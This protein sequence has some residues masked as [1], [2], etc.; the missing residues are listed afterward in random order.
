M[1]SIFSDDFYNFLLQNNLPKFRALQVF[2]W[3]CKHGKVS[4]A[5]MPNIGQKLQRFLQENFF[6]Y[7]PDVSDIQ[8]SIDG[9]TK[10]LL[11]LADANTIETVLIPEKDHNTLCISSQVGCAVGCKFCNTGF[12][13]FIRNLTV[14]EIIGQYIAMHHITGKEISNIV[15]M[16]MGEPLFNVENVLKSIEIFINPDMFGLS[17]RKITLSTSGI[18]PVLEKIVATLPVKL[19]ISL[20]AP[21]DEIRDKI[22]PINKKYNLKNLLHVCELYNKYN[23]FLR[24]TFEYLL[25]KDVNDSDNCAIELAKI[26]G[27]INAKVNIIRFNSWPGSCFTE[28]SAKTVIKFAKILSK[29]GIDAPIRGRHGIDIMAACGQ[30]QARNKKI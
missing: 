18:T 27:K 26:C 25:L 4:F 3:I 10:L 6:I 17:K 20:H 24:I 29:Y 8:R 9:T 13:G 22:M 1:K 2:G 19:A 23:A 15:F 7:M 16:G 12:N 14:D 5:D 21:N 28:S 30:L 11:K